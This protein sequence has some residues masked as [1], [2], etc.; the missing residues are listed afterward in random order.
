MFEWTTENLFGERPLWE[1]VVK[2][3]MKENQVRLVHEKLKKQ[4]KT[5]GLKFGTD[6]IFCKGTKP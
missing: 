5:V 3:G 6:V 2:G 4:I 1:L